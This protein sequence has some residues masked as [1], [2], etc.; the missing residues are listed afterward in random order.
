LAPGVE[1]I[2]SL[3]AQLVEGSAVRIRK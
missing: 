1:V 3:P 2:T